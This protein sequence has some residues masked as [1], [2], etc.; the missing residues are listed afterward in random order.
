MGRF[1]DIPSC[2]INHYSRGRCLNISDLLGSP[3][4]VSYLIAM[5]SVCPTCKSTYRTPSCQRAIYIIK[6]CS[7]CLVSSTLLMP[8]TRVTMFYLINLYLFIYSWRRKFS[9]RNFCPGRGK[10]FSHSLLLA[11]AMDWLQVQVAF[12]FMHHAI[13]CM[14]LYSS[15]VCEGSKVWK[16]LIRYEDCNELRLH[17]CI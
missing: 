14:Y 12:K 6:Q 3:I 2:V 5:D 11:W 8:N 16:R 9:T 13:K 4:N 1:I 17:L 10:L 7:G 15:T